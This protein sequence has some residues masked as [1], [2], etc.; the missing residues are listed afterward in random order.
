MDDCGEL[1]VSGWRDASGSNCGEGESYPWPD[2]NPNGGSHSH[3]GHRHGHGHS[4]SHSRSHSSSS[5]GDCACE[6]GMKEIRFIYQGTEDGVSIALLNPKVAGGV[7]CSFSDVAINTELTCSSST[8]N[9][10]KFPTNTDFEVI[11]ADGT[12]CETSYHTSCSVDIVGAESDCAELVVS[13]YTDGKDN[14]CDDGYEP[15]YCGPPTTTMEP[16]TTTV[17]EPETTTVT[18]PETTTVTSPD[19]TG[20]DTPT[21]TCFCPTEATLTT[22]T[23]I[24]THPSY[25]S[26][27]C[28]G[29]MIEL[30]FT[31]TGAENDVEIDI[32]EEGGDSICQF[33]GVYTGDM[34]VCNVWGDTASGL[35]QTGLDKFPKNTAFKITGDGTTCADAYHTSCS[36]DITGQIMD[37]CGEL[38]VSGWRD[39][40][41]SNCGEGESYPWPDP[42]PNGGSHSHG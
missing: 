10:E 18:E 4:H 26:C 27:D 34:I 29:G 25:D 1:V 21:T 41:G 30:R 22:E 16:D 7:I 38:V 12:A 24:L 11:Y 9:L 14:D 32:S 35:V 6:K 8:A 28:D 36:Q 33:S 17:T 37:D 20:P 2:P 13:G 23:P 15:C 3:D 40:S 5:D 39:A 42:N 31:Y 19:T